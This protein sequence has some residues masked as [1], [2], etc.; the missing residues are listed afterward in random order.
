MLIYNLGYKVVVGKP[1]L[2]R[3][4]GKP[5]HRWEDNIRMDLRGIELEIVDCIYLA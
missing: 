5:K 1:E 3:Q 2:K 4:V